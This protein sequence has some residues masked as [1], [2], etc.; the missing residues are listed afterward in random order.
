MASLVEKEAIDSFMQMDAVTFA[1]VEDKEQVR[2]SVC[3][4][5]PTARVPL[6]APR[7]C[8]GHGRA[9]PA[10]SL[11]LAL[12]KPPSRSSLLSC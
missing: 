1:G 8:R 6:H 7:G 5:V 4:S 2:A 10:L 9:A 12:T 3:L 11:A